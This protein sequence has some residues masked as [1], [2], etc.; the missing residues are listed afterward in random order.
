MP[1]IKP[2]LAL[3]VFSSLLFVFGCSNGAGGNQINF[4]LIVSEKFLPTDFDEIAFKRET[5]PYFQYLVKKVVNQSEFE[6]MWNIYGIGNK[7]PYVDFNEKGVIFIGVQEPGSFPY[8]I[9]S[10]G[11]NLDNKTITVPLSQSNGA[12]TSDATP[13]F[14]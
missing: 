8:K 13:R 1:F 5:T 4:D 7:M 9:K 11:Q 3:A 14:Q 6:K 10:I 12:C 2:Y